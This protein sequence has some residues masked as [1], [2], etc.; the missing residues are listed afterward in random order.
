MI[1]G[2]LGILHCLSILKPVRPITKT[3]AFLR[4]EFSVTAALNISHRDSLLSPPRPV[5]F[6]LSLHFFSH[7][8]KASP[9]GSIPFRDMAITK[10]GKQRTLQVS[11][12]FALITSHSTGWMSLKTDWFKGKESI[13]RSKLKQQKQS[14]C[15]GVYWVLSS[16]PSTWKTLQ[17]P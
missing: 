6:L 3:S 9:D 2:I 4:E 14:D 8:G 11:A 10:W 16:P 7:F 17:L 12:A 5:P 13:T 1:F 15:L